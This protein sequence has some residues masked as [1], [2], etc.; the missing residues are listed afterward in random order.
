MGTAGLHATVHTPALRTRAR[1]VRGAGV[2]WPQDPGACI[3]VAELPLS[4]QPMLP[5]LG[6]C[7]PLSA[8]DSTSGCCRCCS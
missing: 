6:V 4:S 1:V 8:I 3:H 2:A 5:V 7:A